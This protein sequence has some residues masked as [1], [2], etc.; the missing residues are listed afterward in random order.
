MNQ[1]LLKNN[2]YSN[3]QSIGRASGPSLSLLINELSNDSDETLI[4]IAENS[5]HA[6]QLK[7]EIDFFKNKDTKVDLFPEWETLPYDNFSPQKDIVSE[8]IK[9][10]SDQ[11]SLT[12]KIKIITPYSLLNRLPPKDYLLNNSLSLKV[13]Q[14]LKYEQLLKILIEKGFPFVPAQFIQ[15]FKR[16]YPLILNKLDSIQFSYSLV[17]AFDDLEES[18][19]LDFCHVTHIGNKIIAL[20]IVSSVAAKAS[21][22]PRIGPMHGVQPKPNAIPTT[23]ENQILLFFLV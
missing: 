9:I 2:N 7:C 21:I 20:N 23:K 4:V 11:S 15:D 12:K 3:I 13:S 5:N 8:R 18:P 17:G 10:L 1:N 6:N 16:A 19:Y 14:N 22:D